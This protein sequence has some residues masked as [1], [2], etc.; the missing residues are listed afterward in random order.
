MKVCFKCGKEKQLK[1][2]YKHPM[3]KDGH[4]GKCKECTKTDSRKV[5][6]KNIEYYRKY[7]R[8][9]GSRQNKEYFT[10]YRKRNHNKSKAMNA[11]NNAIRDG[12]IKR[13]TSC[14]ICGKSV[15][16]VKHHY[17]YSKPLDV[18]WLCHACHSGIHRSYND[19]FVKKHFDSIGRNP[20]R[21]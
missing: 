21:V 19:E 16:L 2:F 20:C 7:D 12:K 17:D 4:L 13:K 9:R 10:E 8:E 5:R 6:E 14:E 18:V 15:K 11:A 1:D 3:M